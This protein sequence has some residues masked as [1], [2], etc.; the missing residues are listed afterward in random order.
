MKKE[1][2]VCVPRN[3]VVLALLKRQ[4]GAGKHGKGKNAVR[5]Q[6][7]RRIHALYSDTGV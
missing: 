6:E 5:Q 4:A 1:T 7:N 2:R 3:H